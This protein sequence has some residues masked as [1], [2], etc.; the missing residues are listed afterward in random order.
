[1]KTII[2]LILLS[3][4]AYAGVNFTNL[5]GDRA[6]SIPYFQSRQEAIEYAN[7]VKWQ[8]DVL[9]ATKKRLNDLSIETRD[10]DSRVE[11]HT[12]PNA[13][14]QSAWEQWQRVSIALKI[15]ENFKKNGVRG[16]KAMG[17]CFYAGSEPT[18]LVDFSNY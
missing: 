11:Y 9:A 10:I 3:P 15:M 7:R 8:D 16:D 13:E 4:S 14:W 12:Y 2:F 17:A 6:M 1:M 5:S 18:N